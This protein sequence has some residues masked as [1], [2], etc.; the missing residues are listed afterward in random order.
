MPYASKTNFVATNVTAPSSPS[1]QILNG[2]MS[3][4]VPLE[5]QAQIDKIKEYTQ[6]DEKLGSF[7]KNILT[8]VNSVDNLLLKRLA[9]F[10]QNIAA[11]NTSNENLL[12]I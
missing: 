4:Y 7:A 9:S 3:E 1:A 2:D 5:G 10:Y 8:Q 6:D 11:G 12:I